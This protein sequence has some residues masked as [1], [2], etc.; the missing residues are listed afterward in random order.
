M[1]QLTQGRPDQLHQQVRLS[2]LFLRPLR[3]VDLRLQGGGRG[4]FATSPISPISIRVRIDFRLNHLASRIPRGGRG[5]I[6]REKNRSRYRRRRSRAR[7]FRLR[8]T[9]KYIFSSRICPRQLIVFN[10]WNPI[11]CS[12]RTKRCNPILDSCNDLSRVLNISYL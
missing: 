6:A 2:P 12:T 7:I 8:E 11:L 1:E 9:R 5:K 4:R 10:S 3:P